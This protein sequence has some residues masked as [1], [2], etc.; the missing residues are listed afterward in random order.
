LIAGNKE[1]LQLV[2]ANADQWGNNR[3]SANLDNSILLFGRVVL[4]AAGPYPETAG[5]SLS[6]A[7]FQSV[8]LA[9]SMNSGFYVGRYVMQHTAVRP[10]H[11]AYLRSSI[12]DRGT[13]C[14][15][16]AG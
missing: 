9:S 2:T 1:H 4:S 10:G 16:C 15:V 14:A 11:L 7:A 8:A 5:S 12:G 6:V 3:T 13:L